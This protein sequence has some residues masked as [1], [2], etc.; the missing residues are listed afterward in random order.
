[1]DARR[2]NPFLGLA[3]AVSMTVAAQAQ[4]YQG[5][6]SIIP[7]PIMFLPATMPGAIPVI[8]GV[9][10]AGAPVVGAPVGGSNAA[11]AVATPMMPAAPLMRGASSSATRSSQQRGQAVAET[12]NFIVFATDKAWAEEVATTAERQRS[13]L[14]LHWLGTELPPWSSRCPIHVHD[15]PELG[16]GGE[17][18]FVVERG[19]AHNWMMSVQGTRERILDS[20]LPHEISHTIFATHF[21]RLNKYV[22]RWADEG[23][24]TTVEHESEKSK[25]RHYLRKFLQTGR[26]LAFNKMFQLKEYPKDIL[27]LYAQ[28]HSAVQFLID[29]SSPRHFI[30]FL[31]L[32][33]KTENWQASLRTFY[34]YES[35]GEFQARWNKWLFDGSPSDL[36]AYAPLLAKQQQNSIALASATTDLVPSASSTHSR[37]SSDPRA[38]DLQ[39]S[40]TQPS[41]TQSDD[42]L[43]AIAALASAA[44][45]SDSIVAGQQA[46]L[47]SMEAA[48]ALAGQEPA[49]SRMQGAVDPQGASWFQQKLKQTS[50]RSA[51][52]I[53]QHNS[54]SSEQVAG[55]HQ[56]APTPDNNFAGSVMVELRPSSSVS[57]ASLAQP[58]SGQVS[59]GLPQ[60]PQGVNL[61]VLER[62]KRLR[63]SGSPSDNAIYR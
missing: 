56:Q 20:V 12:E 34:G 18:R 36:V 25:H 35:I 5:G 54:F 32:G 33:M 59:T 39:P 55:V 2:Y 50:G 8:A 3:M 14:S 42:S 11:S 15:A 53:P 24:A 38:L 1:M 23:S 22:P 13:E 46:E 28:G 47:L 48:I 60:Q 41:T 40:A 63:I 31:E 49:E 16:A 19:T 21:G 6:Q 4:F 52:P 17:T 44:P 9:P 45:K 58:P 30:Q 29:Q 51:T 57:T 27:P 37:L 62:G 7:Q 43:M 10:V 61:Q 26:G